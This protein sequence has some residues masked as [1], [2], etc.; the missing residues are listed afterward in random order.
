MCPEPASE[1]EDLVYFEHKSFSKLCKEHD[2]EFTGEEESSAHALERKSDNPLDIAVTRLADLERNIE[3]RIEEDIAPGLRVWRRALSEA[4]SAAQVALCI[5]QLQKSVAWEK[6]IMKVYCQ[7]CRKG[8]NE[9][10]LLLCDGCDKGCH[11]YCHRPKITTI[12]DGD[13]FCPACI[14]KASGQTLKIKKLHVKGKKTE[15]KKVKKVTLTGDTEDEDSASTSSSLK[16]GIKDLKK[17]K[18]EENTSISLSKQESFTSVKKP[19]RDDSKDLALCSMILTE[20]ET[21]EDAWPF[22]L[23][24]NLKLVPGY[25]K[26]IKKPMDFS[27]IREKLSSG[28]YPNL[29][30]FALDVRLVFDNCETFNEDDSDIGRAGHS[31][32]K[33]F[34]KK[35]TDTFKVS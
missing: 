25:K 29:E 24:V 33:Y 10:L 6:S 13:W 18:M 8:D 4:R 9:E 5:Q 35:W 21:H 3:R 15:S 31:M 19:K 30:T 17:R 2:G 12:P 16:R 22:L 23:P 26:V 32:R 7:I 1:R 14:A 20:M 27:T 11:T 28:Q 34:E